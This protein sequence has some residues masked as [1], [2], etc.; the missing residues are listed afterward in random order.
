VHR[1]VGQQNQDGGADVAPLA[2][3]RP[4]ATAARAAEAEPA[5]GIEA[6]SAATGAEA[7]AEAGLEAGSKRAVPIGAV[8]THALAEVATGRPTVFVKGAALLRPEAEAV[9]TRWWCEWVVH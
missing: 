1:T 6:E 3:S 7:A 5:A 4:A 2:A 9:P 8:L